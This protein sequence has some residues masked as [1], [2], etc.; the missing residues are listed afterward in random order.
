MIADPEVTK[1]SDVP[2]TPLFVLLPTFYGFFIVND[3]GRYHS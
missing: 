1:L 2:K 3:K